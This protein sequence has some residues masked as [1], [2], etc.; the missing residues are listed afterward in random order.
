MEHIGGDNKKEP[1]DTEGLRPFPTG[2]TVWI[3][4]TCA[5]LYWFVDSVVDAS[6][7]REHTL[8]FQIIK[9]AP[10]ELRVRLFALCL[11]TFLGVFAQ[12]MIK[13]R[14]IDEVRTSRDRLEDTVK[15]LSQQLVPD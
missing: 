14:R 11:L 9:P 1:P 15:I 4:L 7:F 5:A 6:I 10:K 12:N 2:K 3:G 13:R 8:F